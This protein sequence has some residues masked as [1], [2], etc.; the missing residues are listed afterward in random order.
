MVLEVIEGSSV[1]NLKDEASTEHFKKLLAKKDF[2][3]LYKFALDY[4]KSLK[5]PT[6]SLHV[7]DGEWRKYSKFTDN[8]S[9]EERSER[10]KELTDSLSI[11]D[12]Q[13]CIAGD[14]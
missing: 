14:G 7:T 4:V 1:K 10:T 9:E 11:F 13:W 5:L 3:E 2:G 12:T 8:M 6:E